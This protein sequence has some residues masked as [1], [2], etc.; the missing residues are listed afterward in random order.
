MLCPATCSVSL[1]AH[2]FLERHSRVSGGEPTQHDPV[3]PTNAAFLTV[4]PHTNE[5]FACPLSGWLH[6]QTDPVTVTFPPPAFFNDAHHHHPDTEEG[7][8]PQRAVLLGNAS[9][10][11]QVRLQQGI[12][13]PA[14]FVRGDASYEQL[15]QLEDVRVTVS[16]EVLAQ[17]RRSSLGPGGCAVGVRESVCLVCHDDFQEGEEVVTLACSHSFHSGCALVWLARYS[18]KCPVCKCRVV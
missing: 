5:P 11:L 1:R 13:I 16:P 15:V 2:A 18:N 14:S 4:T 12:N 6:A 10:A 17:L 3:V 8:D 7:L 9:P